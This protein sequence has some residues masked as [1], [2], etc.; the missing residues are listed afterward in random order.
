MSTFLDHVLYYL[1]LPAGTPLTQDL[2]IPEGPEMISEFR[3]QMLSSK[4]IRLNYSYL[5]QH[6]VF[7]PNLQQLMIDKCILSEA[8]AK[9]VELY[10]EKFAQN[11]I[12]ITALLTWECPPGGLLKLADTLAVTT[13]QEHI[14]QK[15]TKGKL[16]LPAVSK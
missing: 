4:V 8:M 9:K 11:A 5:Y 16:P 7:D 2:E 14:G 12:I 6:L 3:Q 13:G 1:E 15:L 10:R